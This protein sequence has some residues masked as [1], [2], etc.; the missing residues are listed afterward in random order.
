MV[1][2]RPT[3]PI[4][5]QTIF[6]TNSVSLSATGST[7]SPSAVRLFQP[8]PRSLTLDAAVVA[9]GSN[10]VL[11]Y[12]GIGLDSAGNSTF[13][14]T[15]TVY[16]VGKDPVSVT[17]ADVNGDGIPDLLVVNHDSNNI[18]LLLGRSDANGNFGLTP[19]QLL[20]SGGIGPTDVTVV[21][22]T[23]SPGGI[24][25]EV[26]NA[27]S[28]TVA[29]LPGTGRGTFNDIKPWTFLLEPAELLVLPPVLVATEAGSATA[30]SPIAIINTKAN[31][32][33]NS[34]DTGA[35]DNSQEPP[36][37][38][39][40]IGN[41]VVPGTA[42]VDVIVSG[43]D[44]AIALVP[45]EP[46]PLPPQKTPDLGAPDNAAPPGTE[47][48]SVA[49]LP[50]M[51]SGPLTLPGSEEVSPLPPP[52]VPADSVVR[53]APPPVPVAHSGLA[54]TPSTDPVGTRAPF[55]P[56]LIAILEPEPLNGHDPSFAAATGPVRPS[57]ASGSSRD[58]ES[59][60]RTGTVRGPADTRD[61]V[62]PEDSLVPTEE[63]HGVSPD[64]G[65]RGRLRTTPDLSSLQDLQP[66]QDS[67]PSG[68]TGRLSFS[69]PAPR[70]D[71]AFEQ[72]DWLVFQAGSTSDALLPSSLEWSG[73]RLGLLV[74]VACLFT[75][76]LDNHNARRSHRP[77]ASPSTEEKDRAGK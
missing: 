4:T 42:E 19:G 68:A 20:N 53:L 45:L 33:Q 51:P 8:D 39:V 77:S 61:R 7:P 76:P 38:P 35:S 10:Q 48:G 62:L 46:G 32:P 23:A 13:N 40:N 43:A 65:G 16:S 63:D 11:I 18:S 73:E 41:Q 66:R 47:G 3:N 29:L 52:T 24:A 2:D 28:G 31:L 1:D 70:I 49:S 71:R 58:A 34:P 30:G 59:L 44:S 64:E 67:P 50:A 72:Q 12:Q 36:P 60:P 25:L 5:L 6:G 37:P 69:A 74:A 21:P 54:A 56:I 26:T 17:I 57:V 27:G 15:P 22:D 75:G 55:T 9:G 14:P